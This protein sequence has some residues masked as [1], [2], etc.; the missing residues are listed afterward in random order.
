MTVVVRR[1]C[2]SPS[3]A[4]A[5]RAAV[6]ADNP[7]YVGVSVEGTD[8][9]IRLDTASTASAR[10]TL[11]DLI[12]CLQVAERSEPDALRTRSRDGPLSPPKGR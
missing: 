11:E 10:T 9:V 1:R 5:L 7:S 4:E 12:A 6:A 2:A 3:E 8:L